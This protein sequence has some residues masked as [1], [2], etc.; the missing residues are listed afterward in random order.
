MPQALDQ[1]GRWPLVLQNII[2]GASL[3][4]WGIPYVL[5]AQDGRWMIGGEM[6]SM[7]GAFYLTYQHTKEREI[8]HART[9]MM[10]YGSL[11]GLRYGLGVNELFKLDGG[12]QEDDRQ[13]LWAWIL[14]TSVPV[15]YYG[16]DY[17]YEKVDPSNGQAWAWTMWTGAAGLSSRLIYNVFDSGPDYPNISHLLANYDA[18][19]DRYHEDLAD[20][21][22]RKT[23][24]ELIGYP[25]GLYAGYQLTR[26]KQYSFG[27]AL[28]LIQGWG[29]GYFNTMMIQSLLTDNEDD[30]VFYMVNSLG[31]IGSALAYDRWI[32]SDDYSFGQATLMMLGSASGTA[33]GFGTAILL[34]LNEKEPMLTLAL[35]GYGGGTYLT[36]QILDVK[37]NGALSQSSFSHVSL[38]PTVLTVF[39]S[40]Q[41][42]R[43]TPAL[44][45]RISIK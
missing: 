21:E 17:L 24:A 5:H 32:K 6:I 34:N 2:L 22:K 30:E 29:Y 20:W 31:A 13:T 23:I 27:D 37:S 28:M 36:R 35:L 44:D 14:M 33:F 26:N 45:F 12:D 7:G 18:E 11:L 1:S 25:L 9:Q 16:G 43:M 42:L 8:T 41:K 15:G 40:D 10:R 39:G 4:G 19:W 3:Y 38:A